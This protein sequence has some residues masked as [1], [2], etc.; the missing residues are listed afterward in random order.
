MSNEVQKADQPSV[1]AAGSIANR[2]S[3]DDALLLNRAVQLEETNPPRIL[4][5][6]V[7][8]IFALVTVFVIW[9]SVA[10][11]A[12]KAI[13]PGEIM[14]NTLVTPVQYAEGGIIRTVEVFEGQEIKAGDVLMRMDETQILSELNAIAARLASQRAERERLLAL[15]E[16]RDPSFEELAGAF[17]EIVGSEQRTY[18]ISLANWSAQ[19]D[20]VDA[21]VRAR[22]AQVNGLQDEIVAREQESTALRE[23][24]QIREE[25]EE[26]GAGARLPRLEAQRV[27]ADAEAE[28]AG[29]RT[30][31]ASAEASLA[32][33]RANRLELEERLKKDAFETISRLNGVI[34][35]SINMREG[36]DDRLQRT[37]VTAMTDGVVTGLGEKKSNTVVESGQLLLNIV[38][39]QDK[40]IAE[41]RVS[42]R[43]VGHVKLGMPVLLRVDTYKYGQYGG[44]DGSVVRVSADTFK[45]D[46]GEAYFK[47]WVELEK[48]FVG[49]DPEVNRIAPGMTVTADI[50]TGE[51]SLLAYL[52]RP[53]R[54]S[55]QVAFSE[56]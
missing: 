17:P 8:A 20:A 11:F 31:L 25:L 51:K 19:R 26:T 24:V 54:N 56:R 42:P 14:P 32:E 28:L 37:V 4:E 38:P 5:L 30:D 39:V 29:R 6:S 3:R 46:Q 12:E 2:L 43:D 53:V 55:L 50:K 34:E 48:N 22:L 15:V 47:T 44:I 7:R 9:A 36:L 1:W 33:A 52:A 16:D 45:D 18:A 10:S 13:A 49:V 41:V 23:T 21:Q 27:L 40:L 35:E